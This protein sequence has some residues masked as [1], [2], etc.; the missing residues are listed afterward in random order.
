V[1]PASAIRREG[2]LSGVLVTVGGKATTRWLRLGATLGDRV[3]VL[4]G[5]AAGDTVLV[6]SGRAK[7]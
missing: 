2:D 7:E 6:P 5:L 1:V 4:A 3:E